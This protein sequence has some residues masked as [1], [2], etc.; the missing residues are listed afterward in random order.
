MQFKLHLWLVGNNALYIDFREKKKFRPPLLYNWSKVEISTALKN[1]EDKANINITRK[2]V[3][4][5]IIICERSD[6]RL[7]F[8]CERSLHESRSCVSLYFCPTGLLS[9][10]CFFIW[11]PRADRTQGLSGTLSKM[12]LNVQSYK[13]E[14]KLIHGK[15]AILLMFSVAVRDKIILILLTFHNSFIE[16][17]WVNYKPGTVVHYL[18]IEHDNIYISLFL[19]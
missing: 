8:A 2:Y 19:V 15:C 1:L 10:L 7:Q 14:L 3:S 9:E 4:V 6:V 5:C 18:I 17:S 11:H 16:I 12:S 13:R